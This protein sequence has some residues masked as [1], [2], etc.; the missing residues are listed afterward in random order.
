MTRKVGA[1]REPPG[2]TMDTPSVGWYMSEEEE[3][4]DEDGDD[5]ELVVVPL[6]GDAGD[7]DRTAD[8]RKGA[9]V[10]DASALAALRWQSTNQTQTSIGD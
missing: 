9:G 6:A 5:E 10:V 4:D 3:D 2:H 8:C 7:P 1:T